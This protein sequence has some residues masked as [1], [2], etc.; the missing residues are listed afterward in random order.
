[1]EKKEKRSGERILVIYAGIIC[2]IYMAMAVFG[3]RYL[4]SDG[5]NYFLN[6]ASSGNFSIYPIGRATCDRLMQCLAITGVKCGID[7]LKIIGGLFAIG[8]TF[9][10]SFSFLFSLKVCIEHKRRDLEILLFIIDSMILFFYGFFCQLES[11]IGVTNYLCLLLLFLLYDGKEGCWEKIELVY[12]IAGSLLCYHLNEYYC[13]WSVVLAAI[14]LYR[15][16]GKRNRLNKGFAILVIWHL[17]CAYTSY[18][19][20]SARGEVPG[21]AESLIAIFNRKFFILIIGVLIF[22]IIISLEN[23]KVPILIKRSV[24]LI[25][26]IGAAYYT[27][28]RAGAVARMGY[29][30]RFAL[31]GGGGILG[32]ILF[33]ICRNGDKI[34]VGKMETLCTLITVLVAFYMLLSGIQFRKFNTAYYD[35]CASE[36]TEGFIKE[37]DN[38]MRESFYYIDWISPLQSV[39]VQGIRGKKKIDT[40]ISGSESFIDQYSIETYPNLERYGINYENTFRIVKNKN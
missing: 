6:V 4:Y 2:I 15:V 11:V 26:F 5:S 40:I 19:S 36:T 18:M 31:F 13:V 21:L 3:E 25:F 7:S 34:I 27:V 16:L 10:P 33:I 8:C 1:M 23:F 38:I 35:I 14:M 9:W 32:I 24:E 12:M 29:D 17:I 22:Y 30:I 20:I 39:A 28:T 37:E